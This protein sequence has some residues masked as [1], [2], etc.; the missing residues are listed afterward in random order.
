MS[1]D[2]K[3]D[4]KRVALTQEVYD[5]LE[6]EVEKIKAKG[7]YFK[8]NE[9]KL[10]S[11]IVE[12]FLSQHLEKNRKKI[13]QRFF[14]KKTYLK[15]LIEKSASEEELS[16]SLNHFFKTTKGKKLKRS[17]ASKDEASEAIT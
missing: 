17:K 7:S 15:S 6:A 4:G 5:A 9:S 10:A 1:S 11:V 8:V 2:N 13:E 14:D 16:N 12:L 3:Q